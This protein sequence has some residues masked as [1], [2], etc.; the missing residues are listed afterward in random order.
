ME[1]F[2]PRCCA[3]HKEESLEAF[4]LAPMNDMEKVVVTCPLCEAKF[5]VTVTFHSLNS[6]DEGEQF[7]G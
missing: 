5:L 2:C 6:E 7:N 1:V 4:V 3:V